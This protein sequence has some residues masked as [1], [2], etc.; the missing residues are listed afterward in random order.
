MALIGQIRKK[1]W[2]LILT[3][4]LALAAFIIM[5]MSSGDKSIFGSSQNIAGTI[6][7]E[8]VGWTEFNRAENILYANAG[9][10]VFGRRASLWNYFVEDKLVRKEARE[11]GLGVGKSELMDLQ[12]SQDN[13]KLS[14]VIIQR[15]SDPATGQVN[16]Q[17]LNEIKTAI[18][19]RNITNPDFKARW[20]FQETE[21]VKTTLQ[22]KLETLVSKAIYTP[23]W[24]AEMMYANTE[25]KVNFE[26]VKIP[27]DKID[28][29]QVNLTDA[30]YTNYMNENKALY[31]QDEEVRKIDYAVFD[32]KASAADEK[33]IFD[34]LANQMRYF[35]ETES[36]SIFIENNFGTISGTYEKRSTFNRVYADTLFQIAPGTVVGPYKDGNALVVAKVIDRKVVPDS[37]RARHILISGNDQ[38]TFARGFQT[39]DSLKNLIEAGTHRFDS[40]A[41]KFSQGPSS[42]KGGDLGFA[43]PGGMVKPFNDLIFHNADEGE[44]NIIATQF[45]LHLVE[46]TDKKFINNEQGVKVAMLRQNIIPSEETISTVNTK[47]LEFVTNNTTV[48]AMAAAADADPSI[49]LETSP[50]VKRNDFVLGSLGSGQTSRDIIKWAFGD[51]SVGEVSSQVYIYQN[52]VDFYDEKFVIAG[53]RSQQSAGMPSV[54]F[55]RDDIAI[56]VRNYKKGQMI[57]EQINGKDL[58]AVAGSFPD[59][60]VESASDINF[61]AAVIPNAGSEPKVIAS[62]FAVADNQTSK[63]IIGNTGVYVVK[64]TNKTT[65]GTPANLPDIRRQ[66]NTTMRGQVRGQ[67]IEGLKSNATI[68]DQRSRVY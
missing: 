45:G 29:S 33:A 68:E 66:T 19:T 57:Q 51:A 38:A 32:V 12:F 22:S 13:R 62:A 21:I 47:A 5:D 34:S 6:E 7:G 37:V 28:D 42:S 44:L 40:L 55:I 8:K 25:Q 59:V 9:G 14:P 63:A 67:I 58:N 64:P 49:T 50:P 18:E 30:D 46:V 4:G 3:I 65:V 17:Q 27:F 16:R 60:T 31:R 1:S 52:E 54:N 24:M 43:A 23:S 56:Q 41:T 39:L 11:M 20:G 61:S 26:Y 36:D 35:A 48:T 53:L 15:Y 10:D 2:L